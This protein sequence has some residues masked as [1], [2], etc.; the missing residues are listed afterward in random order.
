MRARFTAHLDEFRPLR[1]VTSLVAVGL[2]ASYLLLEPRSTVH[3]LEAWR[4]GSDGVAQLGATVAGLLLRLLLHRDLF[5]LAVNLVVLLALGARVE[6]RI[7]A[8]RTARLLL[9][10]GLLGNGLELCFANAQFV[11]LSPSLY[12]LLAYWLIVTQLAPGRGFRNTYRLFA[13]P[14]GA[15]GLL[16]CLELLFEGGEVA[17]FSHLGGALSGLAAAFGG[18]NK[19]GSKLR[20][21]N[22]RDLGPVLDI[23][24]AHDEDDADEAE[25]SIKRR[26]AS[27]MY[28]LEEGGQIIGVTGAQPDLDAQGIAWLS[29]TYLHPE[30]KSQ[31]VGRMMV[32]E[33]LA[34]LR[35]NNVRKVFIA[36]SDYKED[37]EDVYADAR[38]FYES[39]GA[40]LEL[41]QRDY[42][43]SGE[44]R[45]VYGLTVHRSGGPASDAKANDPGTSSAVPPPPPPGRASLGDAAQALSGRTP[46]A[47]RVAFT[48][49]QRAP[50]SDGGRVLQWRDRVDEIP[51]G[52]A[53]E[54]APDG[55][56]FEDG[57]Q[58]PEEQL[59]RIIAEAR[60][61][62]I[63]ALYLA[64]PEEIS[65]AVEAALE[66]KGFRHDGSLRAYYSDTESE[67]HWSLD[68]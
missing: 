15:V 68:L 38:R 48:G 31:G 4:G 39:L 35:A 18:R 26:Q 56:Q 58:S 66:S 40:E 51:S 61:D 50:E 30:V 41:L 1:T 33:M 19:S 10:C 62:G 65:R 67:E 53:D 23:I 2:I 37:G 32:D 52:P 6:S 17:I 25:E 16:L 54:A 7:G 8:W 13:L 64:L 44:A 59:E 28:V 21:M 11:G 36:T 9:F 12:G 14:V 29:W 43:Q 22:M 3:S 34:I 49:H 55:A 20:P 63:R 47:P 57:D 5:H 46:A 42:H 45:Y 24:E 60:A 27:G